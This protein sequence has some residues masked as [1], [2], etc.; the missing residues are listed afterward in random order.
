MRRRGKRWRYTQTY[1]FYDMRNV[2]RNHE[3]LASTVHV[4][5]LPLKCWVYRKVTRYFFV[6]A[7]DRH[8]KPNVT[9]YFPWWSAERRE[10]VYK[11]FELQYKTVKVYAKIGIEYIKTRLMTI[12]KLWYRLSVIRDK[13]GTFSENR[14]I[15]PSPTRLKN[16]VGRYPRNR[17]CSA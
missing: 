9:A 16:L 5:Y 3:Q 8:P 1:W 13:S 12:K 15:L 2:R 4:T 7:G 17:H 11:E 14:Y 10:V 6:T